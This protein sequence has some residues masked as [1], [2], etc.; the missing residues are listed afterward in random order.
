MKRISQVTTTELTTLLK[1]RINATE[2]ELTCGIPMH[3]GVCT[4]YLIT[5]R[6]NLARLLHARRRLSMNI[7]Y[8]LCL[9]SGDADS[10]V[11]M[12]NAVG[13]LSLDPNPNSWCAVQAKSQCLPSIVGIKGY[14]GAS[15]LR[16]VITIDSIDNEKYMPEISLDSGFLDISAG[17]AKAHNRIYDGHL[18]TIDGTTGRIYSGVH[19]AIKAVLPELFRRLT[20]LI[21]ESLSCYGPELGWE[22]VDQTDLYMKWKYSIKELLQDQRVSEV[23][24]RVSSW[25][26]EHRMS[27]AGTVH[28][29][30]GA[31]QARLLGSSIT[32]D[33]TEDRLLVQPL[34]GNYGIGLLRTERIFTQQSELD[35]LR[36]IMLN[37]PIFCDTEVDAAISRYGSFITSKYKQLMSVT[38]GALSV[39]RTLC[40]PNNK[41]FSS[42]FDAESFS[43]QYNKDPRA[44]KDILEASHREAEIFH[45]IRGTRSHMLNERLAKAEIGAYLRSITDISAWDSAQRFVFLM[46]MVTLPAEAYRFSM[47]LDEVAKDMRARGEIVPV[48][49]LAI[50]IETT[51]SY[52]NLERFFTV[53][54]ESC[55]L[56]GFFFGGN[57][58][59]A[60]VLNM[61]RDDAVRRLIPAYEESG[62]LQDNPFLRL[63]DLV[64]DVI[65]KGVQRIRQALGNRAIVG[66]GGEQAADLGSV[67]KLDIE[68]G[69][70]IDFVSTSPDRV[71]EHYIYLACS[72]RLII[73]S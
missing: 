64:I 68:S 11:Y 7:P 30:K 9:A 1:D 65:A 72:Q 35:D 41:L 31:I 34:T 14:I 71:V 5:N 33:T 56:V 8:V 15:P 70:S 25:S 28:T 63:N 53:G 19:A 40:M 50:M 43:A 49:D 51:A 57:D 32:W 26:R 12:Q 61:N 47:W 69:H 10:L 29:V 24:G 2:R 23:L 27:F 21:S 6:C 54:N 36:I 60:A 59:T 22:M 58:L 17:D 48:V 16:K 38:S 18:I 62:L 39:V 20:D 44:V 45:G 52:L 73:G 4:G 13:F 55:K 37:T 46:S 3:P 67:A 42:S 66:F